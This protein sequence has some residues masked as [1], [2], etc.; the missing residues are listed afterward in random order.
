M[1]TSEIL[2]L[3]DLPDI[4]KSKY[5]RMKRY[6]FFKWKNSLNV[7]GYYMATFSAEVTF[8]PLIH[9]VPKWPANAAR[10]LKWVWPFWDIITAWTLSI[11]RVFLVLILPHSGWIRTRNTLYTDTF[12]AGYALKFRKNSRLVWKLKEY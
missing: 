12:H 9:N 4:Q 3:V 1:M 8:K 5:L 7:K 10:F 11:F 6:F 2:M